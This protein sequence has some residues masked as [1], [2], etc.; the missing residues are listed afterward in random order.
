MTYRPDMELIRRLAHL[1]ECCEEPGEPS[2]LREGYREIVGALD[3]EPAPLQH[4]LRRG[5]ELVEGAPDE[6]LTAGP[7]PDALAAALDGAERY[8]FEVDDEGA[9][10]LLRRSFRPLLRALDPEGPD[11]SEAEEPEAPHSGEEAAG[12]SG[13]DG[14]ASPGDQGALARDSVR[15]PP[16]AD[17]DLLGDFLEESAEHLIQAEGSVLALEERPDDEEAVNVLFRA[18][19]TIKGSAGFLGLDHVTDLSHRAETLFERVRDREVEVTPAVADLALHVIDVLRALFRCVDEALEGAEPEVPPALEPLVTLLDADDL[20]ERLAA[21]DLDLP[22]SGEG[23]GGGDDDGGSG[24][25]GGD[26][27]SDDTV[28][29]STDRLDRL[30]DLV[31][32]LVVA[33]SMIAENPAAGTGGSGFDKTVKRSAKILRELQDLS[34]SMRMVP[35]H[36]LFRKISRVVRD[37][38]RAS[39]KPVRLITEGEETELD[40]KMVDVIADPLLHMARN[41]IA[42]GIEDPETRR[43][44]GKP[45][46]G[47]IDL[48]ARQEGGN[49]VIEISDDGAGMEREAIARKAIEAGLITSDEGMSDQEIYEMIFQPGFTTATELTDISGRGVGM[50]VVKRSVE[51]LRG[52]VEIASEP[53]EGSVFSIQLPLTLA[54][55]DGILVRVGN[56]RFIVPTISI[57]VTVRPDRDDLYTVA[58][59]GEMARVRGQLLPMARLHRLYGIRGA[60]RDPTKGLLM[61][62]GEGNRQTALL[63]DE[64]LGQEQLV[65]K[66]LDGAVDESPGIAGGAIL[67]DGEVGLILDPSEL[68]DVMRRCGPERS[69][70]PLRQ[71]GHESPPAELRVKCRAQVG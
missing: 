13:E 71:V 41:A 61:V 40:R 14:A 22:R 39:K 35:L 2:V 19:H 12:T 32:E 18:F 54:L 65:V 25:A 46:R 1:R 27:G 67:G 44:R 38:S 21:D 50:D 33:H 60:T 29:V 63:V 59:R 58:G 56:E 16:D 31:G 48:A 66:A 8:V 52:R 30:V 34:T 69:D 6:A 49:V 23:S 70:D 43:A 26:D 47:R 24:L 64:L 7:L 28:R 4:L 53:G 51:S 55:T 68:V 45:E 3:E 20:G 11:A 10:E 37:V 5:E 57:Q 9:A 62:V 17:P 36:R 15:L 42:H